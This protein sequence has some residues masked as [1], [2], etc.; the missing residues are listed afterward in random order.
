MPQAVASSGEVSGSDYLECTG[1]GCSRDLEI[2][3]GVAHGSRVD[4]EDV[5][6]G[7]SPDRSVSV[8]EH[9]FVCLGNCRGSVADQIQM[10]Y[11]G[12]GRTGSDPTGRC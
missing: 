6:A 1:R 7:L 10:L 5:P 8:V 9:Q 4:G 11:E 12:L 3:T 2:V